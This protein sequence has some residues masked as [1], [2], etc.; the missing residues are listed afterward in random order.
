M[1]KK[2]KIMIDIAMTILFLIMMGYHQ[3]GALLHE[4]YGIV[5]AILFLLHNLINWK[6]YSTILK[7]KYSIQRIMHIIINILLLIAFIG[8][9]VSGIMMS[10][11]VFG[12][13]NL[14]STMFARRLHM[15]S[16]SWSFLLMSVHLGLHWSMIIVSLRKY[17]VK[18]W[19]MQALSI[20]CILFGCYV[21]IQK[22]FYNELFLLVDFV[23]LNYQET[24]PIFLIKQIA[25]MSPFVL[26]GYLMTK[27]TKTRRRGNQNE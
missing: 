22:E 6:W 3:T 15:L 18:K 10:K 16:T 8:A 26:L 23:F 20:V 17:H 11:Y 7:G 5:L 19:I 9:M 27:H 21:F 24:L 2:V 4:S 14:Q 1:K 12:F 13:L 25:L